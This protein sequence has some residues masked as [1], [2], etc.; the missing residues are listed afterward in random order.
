MW[1]WTLNWNEVRPDL[2]VGSCP[3]EPGDL[4][5]IRD[6]VSPTAVFS[7]QS[8]LCLQH[9]G[10]DYAA[11]RAYGQNLGL[12]MHRVPMRDFDIEHQQERLAPAV[13]SLAAILAAGHRVYAHC[14]AGLG[15]A[16]LVL[17]AYLTLVE[18]MPEP[19]AF[20]LVKER[21][22][23]AVPSP[24]ALAGCRAELVT[25]H[26]AAIES[27]ALRRYRAR[28]SAG[29][30]GDADT[31]WRVAEQQVLSRELTTDAAVAGEA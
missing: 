6:E 31:D 17:V 5:R 18:R 22:P 26:R 25:S 19:E 12:S 23:G 24:Q 1:T 11:H 20:A 4:L 29:R 9:F 15:R 16:P 27:E 30:D 8:D 3:M 13:R 21:R 14:T 7:L 2:V 28:L 10:I